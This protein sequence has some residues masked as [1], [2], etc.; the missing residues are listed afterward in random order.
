MATTAL[1]ARLL[2]VDIEKYVFSDGSLLERKWTVTATETIELK[3]P[4]VQ[5]GMLALRCND[6]GTI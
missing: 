1:L 6:P 2:V 4:E 5:H 3:R